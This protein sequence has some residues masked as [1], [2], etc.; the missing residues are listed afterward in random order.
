MIADLSPLLLSR[1]VEGKSGGSD[2]VPGNLQGRLQ[3]RN[4]IHPP[5]R[6]QGFEER[7]IEGEQVSSL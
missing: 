5:V 4:R 2:R 3:H 1:R 6:A 7:I